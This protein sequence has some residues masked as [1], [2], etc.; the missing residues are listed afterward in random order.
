MDHTHDKRLNPYELQGQT[1]V[2]Q[3][4]P[5][6]SGEHAVTTTTYNSGVS[7]FATGT[8]FTDTTT[9][10]PDITIPDSSIGGGTTTVKTSGSIKQAFTVNS[11]IG[12]ILRIFEGLQLSYWNSRTFETFHAQSELESRLKL[13]NNN[14]VQFNIP[15]Y[16]VLSLFVKRIYNEMTCVTDMMFGKHI[17]IYQAVKKETFPLNDQVVHR[18]W[19]VLPTYQKLKKIVNGWNKNDDV[20]FFKLL[21]KYDKKIET[22]I[23]GVSGSSN[24][25]P[26]NLT[27]GIE[28]SSHSMTKQIQEGIKEKIKEE[29]L[30]DATMDN[31]LIRLDAKG[32]SFK[33]FL[34]IKIEIISV[35]GQPQYIFSFQISH[36]NE[37]INPINI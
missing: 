6:H 21:V 4:K 17:N 22:F 3:S 13:L 24:E 19:S 15:N 7:A 26:N 2:P 8:T 18:Y 23:K 31:L 14:G 12:N 28:D 10:V 27:L 37:F 29:F 34:R 1:Y 25:F 9:W 35:N 5:D 16:F 33:D 20:N 32:Y 36:N 30:D 11:N